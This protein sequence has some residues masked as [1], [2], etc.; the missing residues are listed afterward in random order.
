MPQVVTHRYDPAVEPCLNL[1]SLQDPEASWVLD[2]L[3]GGLRPTLKPE[4]LNRRVETERWLARAASQA[5]G[6]TFESRPSYFFLGDFSHLVDPSRPA[7]LILP[8]SKLPPDAM[9]FTLGDSMTVA[10]QPDRR[11]FRLEEV[12]SLF[13]AGDVMARYGFSDRNGF[14]TRFVEVQCWQGFP[15]LAQG[16]RVP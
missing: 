10:E 16:L 11:V 4:Y 3:R 13:R 8:L 12:I 14:Q 7:A 2:R 6:R 15:Q 5:L 9:T 1:C